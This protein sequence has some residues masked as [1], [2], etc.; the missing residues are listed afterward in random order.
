VYSRRK[1]G[2][3]RIAVLFAEG[4][5][6]DGKGDG[7][8]NIAS[9]EIVKTIRRIRNNDKVKAVVLRVNSP[10]GSALASEVILRELQLLREKKPLI[11]SMGDVAASGGYYIACQA[12]SIFAM[13]TTITGSIGV[14]A[15]LFNLEGMMKHKLGITFDEVKNAPYADFPTFSRPL[16]ADEAQRM[17][18]HVDTVYGLFKRRVAAARRMD[19]T[20]VDSIA[21][22]RVWSGADALAIGLVDGL[23]N[24]DRALES[25]AAK[26]GL[27]EYQVVTYPDRPDRFE[28]IMKQLSDG[29]MSMSGMVLAGIKEEFSEEYEL[30]RQIKELR[31][32]NGKLMMALPFRIETTR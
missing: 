1:S 5:I 2:D 26:A 21:Q 16:T 22:G 31:S 9:E 18:R 4:S 15:M 17:Q 3:K 7:N 6:V 20:A 27:K 29:S 14:F 12:D 25:A 24:L 13:P 32:M 28:R 10:G 23:G 11:V 30:Y 8:F 19:E